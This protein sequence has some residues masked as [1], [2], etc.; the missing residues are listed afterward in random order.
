MSNSKKR[1]EK[2]NYEGGGLPRIGG[3]VILSPVVF[4]LGFNERLGFP[5]FPALNLGFNVGL[6]PEGG[7]VR[8]PVGA[9]GGGAGGTGSSA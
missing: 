9:T 1:F 5:F 2:L 7:R 3:R 8:P 6:R 4:D